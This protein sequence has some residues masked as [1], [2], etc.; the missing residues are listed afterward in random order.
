[1]KFHTLITF[2]FYYDLSFWGAYALVCIILRLVNSHQAVRNVF[3]LGSSV[4]MLLALPRFG[5]DSLAFI[6][7]VS[8]LTLLVG[9]FLNTRPDADNKQQKVLIASVSI[10]VLISILVF[11]K[12]RAVQQEFFNV[13]DKERA[14][15]SGVIFIIGI[16]YFTFKMIHFVAESYKHQIEGL[17]LLRFLNYSFFFPSYIAGPITRYNAFRE[18][19]VSDKTMVRDDLKAGSTR[20]VHGLFKKFVLCSIVWPYA[21]VNLPSPISEAGA[22]QIIMGM[23]AY[24]L[25]FYFDFAGYSDIAIGSAKIMGINL[26]ENF[27]AP[28]LKRNIQQLW[29]SWH[30]SLT[31]WLTDYVYWP[32]AKWL[33]NTKYLARRPVFLSN[34]S[35]MVT[36][37]ICGM[38]H[39]EGWNFALWGFYHG[40]GLASLNVYQKYKRKVRNRWIKRYFST[41][42]SKLIGMV[43]TFNFFVVGILLFSMDIKSIKALLANM[44]G[45]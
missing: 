19:L 10:L 8:L 26:P 37:I 44:L 35:I 27:N 14:G 13:T 12:Y 6:M 2:D 22:M 20:V 42:Y 31:R 16:S 11:F 4:L 41:R 21:L 32:L 1:M 33:R 9:Y 24:T 38:W 7:F 18:T 45:A 34:V 25:Y 43:L 15:A 28:F 40:L 23:Y 29:A 3:L 5:V 36:F 39:G 30:M 17:T